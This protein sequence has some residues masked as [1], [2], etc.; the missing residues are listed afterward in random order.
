MLG[1]VILGVV[2]TAPAYSVAVTLAFLVAVV[3]VHAPA[4][5]LAAFIPIFCMTIVER[6]FVAR[7]PDCG[8]V[9]VWVGRSLGP[10]AGWICS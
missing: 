7:E 9:F 4:L 6:E 10:R 5:L 3:G 8:T 1:S 2:Q